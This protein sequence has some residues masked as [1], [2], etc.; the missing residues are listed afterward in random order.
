MTKRT[1]AK[2]RQH[3]GNVVAGLKRG[4]ADMR[5]VRRALAILQLRDRCAYCNAIIKPLDKS[6]DHILPRTLGGK[7]RPDN[8][9]VCHRRCNNLKGGLRLE[10]FER[11]Q[12][13]LCS[14]VSV[15]ARF[16]IER[17]LLAGGRIFRGH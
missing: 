16:D 2:I 8:Y 3:F 10:D 5:V 14:E 17:R 7:D 1:E 15:A 6:I 4:G 11:L 13:F 9:A 12:K